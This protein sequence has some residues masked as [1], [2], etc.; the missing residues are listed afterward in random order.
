VLLTRP[1]L[2]VSLSF[3]PLLY[4]SLLFLRYFLIFIAVFLILIQ[5]VFL[6]I[7]LLAWQREK[8][9]YEMKKGEGKMTLTDILKASADNMK[10]HG[11][12]KKGEQGGCTLLCSNPKL[13]VSYILAEFM[14]RR[15]AMNLVEVLDR[16]Q[17]KK[18]IKHI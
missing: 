11:G 17:V 3:I 18:P 10:R 6:A 14:R 16:L 7:V 1:T 8:E 5:N 15:K 2:H 12:H 4:S 13:A 9:L